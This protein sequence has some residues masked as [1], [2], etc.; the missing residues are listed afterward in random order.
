MTRRPP[1]HGLAVTRWFAG[2][3]F[4]PGQPGVYE[5]RVPLAPYSY[6][7]GT[8][9]CHSSQTVDGAVRLRACES[10]IQDRDWRGL[11]EEPTS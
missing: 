7:T 2:A 10:L 5:R 1:H 11:A 9:W 6:W 8:C 3:A 4:V